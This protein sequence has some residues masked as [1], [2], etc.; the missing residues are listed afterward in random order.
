MKTIILTEAGRQIGFGHLTRCIGLYQGF[1]E[2]NIDTEIIVN[3]DSTIDYLLKR[4]KHKKNNWLKNQ[5]SILKQ[6]KNIDI[7]VIDSYLAP[8]DFYKEI[9]K[10]VK[11][12][13]YIDDYKRLNYPCGIVVNPSI[14]G[15]KLNY[16][17]K[18]DITYLLGKDY[19][20][21]RKEFW[22]VP[23]KKINKEIRNVLIA[24][25]GM[26][27][28]DL[29]CK[30]KN[31]LKSKFDFDVYAVSPSEK[32]TART[33]LNLMMKADICISGGGQTTYELARVGV[34]TIGICFAR[35]QRLNLKNWRDRG[36]I[37]S[38]IWDSNRIL[39]KEKELQKA[40]DKLT[41]FNE[42]V[43][44]SLKGRRYIGGQSTEKNIEIFLR[45]SK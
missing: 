24:F 34:P 40:I 27:H 3:S 8:L 2:K 6:L 30:I 18:K 1:R 45:K 10:K 41:F 38:I 43:S 5:E 28:Q 44:C 20:I 19:I 21:L 17:Q 11:T 4:I 33:M 22:Q 39:F 9:S 23:E 42:R 29:A 7:A 25:G 12:P 26:N 14:Y 36:F 15:D 13:V 31:Y 16:P 37:K 32:V 35:N